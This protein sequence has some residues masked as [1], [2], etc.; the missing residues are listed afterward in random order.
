M[1]TK[2]SYIQSQYRGANVQHP[3][4]NKI[5]EILTPVPPMEVQNE[6]VRILD[7]FTELTTRKKQ[8]EYYRDQLLTFDNNTPRVK[9]E[10]ICTISAGGD[11][12]KN[13]Y[14]K[15]MIEKYTIPIY[16]NGVGEKALYGY[17]NLAKITHHCITI[18][19]RGTIG[20]CA[21]REEPFYPVVR[22]ICAIPKDNLNVRF[23]KYCVDTIQFQV[24]TTGIPQLTVP[25]VKE[26]K[27]PFPP[28]E[29]Q[30]KV[31]SILDRFDK[32]CND[33]S[34][35]LPAEIEARKKQYE[36][37]RDKLLSFKEL[38]KESSCE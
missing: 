29:E 6:I 8:Y 30:N 20:Y 36:Y 21:L 3:D 19:A 10:D 2:N 13:N 15:E 9:L 38:K 25:T 28:L 17:T 16:S 12:P 26:Y 37:Y 4:M 1:L 14:S 27:I 33:I 22:L 5:L 31:V 18:A 24:P 32:L 35:G 7:N 11:V 23:L 34:E